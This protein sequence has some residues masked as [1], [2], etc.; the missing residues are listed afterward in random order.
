MHVLYNS[1]EGKGAKSW[2]ELKKAIMLNDSQFTCTYCM[3]SLQTPGVN[4]NSSPG[5]QC[6]QKLLIA[7]HYKSQSVRLDPSWI[8]NPLIS[9]C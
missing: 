6:L 8:L 5:A 2:L 4:I 1:S 9:N 7:S 3:N